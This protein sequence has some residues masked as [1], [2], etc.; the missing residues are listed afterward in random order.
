MYQLVVSQ[1]TLYEL[2]VPALLITFHDPSL[3]LLLWFKST[4]TM[5]SEGIE[6]S[7]PEH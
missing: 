3:G 1:I 4:S 7:T 5:L 6:Y 2:Q